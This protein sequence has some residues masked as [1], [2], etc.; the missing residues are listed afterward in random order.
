MPE[1]HILN[2][3]SI[4]RAIMRQTGAEPT[5]SATELRRAAEGLGRQIANR[6]D[7]EI[8]VQLS[9]WTMQSVVLDGPNPF[10]P[11][12]A[13]GLRNE[14]TVYPTISGDLMEI[15]RECS[16]L[17]V[18]EPNRIKDVRSISKELA[19]LGFKIAASNA[20]KIANKAEKLRA[21]KEEKYVAITDAKIKESLI[22]KA[23]KYN[24]E[25]GRPNARVDYNCSR[26]A[27]VATT[28]DRN[29]TEGVGL[30]EWMECAIHDYVGIPP[31]NVL[32]A[33]RTAKD[34]KIFDQ[35]TVATVKHLKDPLLLGRI[36]G[37][38]DARFFIAQWGEDVC[39][40][41]LI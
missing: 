7:E 24:A 3:E 29:G 13:L 31:S 19:E 37:V 30:I 34:K 33:L 1:A 17:G 26:T 21:I 11:G 25:R 9:P 28:C 15:V 22:K 5:P 32:D 23:A 2:Q 14:S 6:W 36:E 27:A 40:D 38:D 18:V 39:L 12:S 8:Q 16:V 10:A 20:A 4:R 41:D 35:F